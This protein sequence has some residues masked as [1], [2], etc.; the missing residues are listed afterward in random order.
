MENIEVIKSKRKTISLQINSD[1]SIVLK[2]PIYVSDTE[3]NEFIKQKSGWIEKHLQ[4]I[5]ERKDKMS[6]INP[7]TMD[8][9]YDLAD[10]AMKIIPKR[11]AHYAPLI[12][13]DYGRITIRNQKSRWGSCS[14]RG[15]LNFNCLLMLM[16]SDVIDYVVV[17]ELCHRK[18]MN[19]SKKFWLEVEKILPDYKK[20]LSWL[21]E[22]GDEIMMR[23]IG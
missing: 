2:A 5:Q 13:V 19:H 12:G 4:K 20:Q 16:P 3:V 10:K 22:H 14:G 1:G 17:H 6:N 21:K 18:E 11:T 23:M 8:E 7:L 9:I 15:N